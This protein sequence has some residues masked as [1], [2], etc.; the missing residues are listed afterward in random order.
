MVNDI[1]GIRATYGVHTGDLTATGMDIV[2]KEIA[3][4]D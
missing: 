3:Y 2:Y 1:I 4:E